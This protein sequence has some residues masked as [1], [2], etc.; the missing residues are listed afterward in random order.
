MATATGPPDRG[1]GSG[2]SPAST[3]SSA[4]QRLRGRC[5][6]LVFVALAGFGLTYVYLRVVGAG[7]RAQVLGALGGLFIVLTIVGIGLLGPVLR[8]QQDRESVY[9]FP[10]SSTGGGQLDVTRTW[11]PADEELREF[12]F[13][14]AHD[15]REPARTAATHARLAQREAGE[16]LSDQANDDIETAVWAAKRVDTL[17][18]DL[19]TYVS[20]ED[21][22]PEP[23]E[24]EDV[25]H[26]VIARLGARIERFEAEIEVAGSTTVHGDPDQIGRLLA[27]LIDNAMKFVPPG[28][29]PRIEITGEATEQGARIE[30]ADNGIGMDPDHVDRAFAIFQRLHAPHEFQGTGTGL[31]I[32][33]RIT[34]LHGGSIDV[35]SPP[36]DGTLFRIHLPAQA[37]AAEAEALDA[38]RDGSSP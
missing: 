38:S 2:G 34:E 22:S 13:L 8:Q 33:R 17:L 16:E 29:R 6:T 5:L 25:V 1:E 30:V 27:E 12:T 3:L 9:E 19:L 4:R 32:C 20:L 14:V 31:A 23:M 7:S 35:E 28:Q 36:G 18:D 10:G 11:T 26:D 24:V 21:P 37:R 15:L